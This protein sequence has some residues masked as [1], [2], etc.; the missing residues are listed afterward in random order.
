MR[1]R[2]AIDS[3]DPSR[4]KLGGR[5]EEELHFGHGMFEMQSGILVGR[6]IYSSGIPSMRGLDGREERWEVV[7]SVWEAWI[8]FWRAAG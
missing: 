6:S 1:Q 2:T 4:P 8:G 3:S 5:G 7:I